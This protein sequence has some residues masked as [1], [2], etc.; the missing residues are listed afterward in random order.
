M[1]KLGLEKKSGQLRNADNQG[2]PVFFAH[3][4]ECMNFELAFKTTLFSGRR[5]RKEGSC[6]YSSRAFWAENFGQMSSTKV[7][8]LSLILIINNNKTFRTLIEHIAACVNTCTIACP[9]LTKLYWTVHL[10]CK[11][12]FL[13]H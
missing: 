10:G 7:S 12:L 5:D 9:P 6:Y 3:W 8:I 13:Y 11:S 2:S 1:P 4:L